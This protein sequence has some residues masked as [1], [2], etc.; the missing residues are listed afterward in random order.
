MAPC[1]LL[2][3]VPGPCLAHTNLYIR[4]VRFTTRHSLTPAACI[5]AMCIW[6]YSTL[7]CGNLL[8]C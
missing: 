1:W 3:A 7:P 6:L 5:I 4:S 8:G 2:Q